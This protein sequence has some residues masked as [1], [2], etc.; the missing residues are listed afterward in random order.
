MKNHL[1]VLTSVTFFLFTFTNFIN[2]QFE[3]ESGAW[4][5]S[6]KKQHAHNHVN[7]MMG[8]NSPV[9][10]FDVLKYTMDMDLYNNFDSPYPHDFTSD[11]VVKFKVDSTLSSIELNAYQNS[12]QINSV[13]LAGTAFTHQNDMLEITLDNTYQPGDIVEVS[14]D[15]YH[16]DVYDGAFYSGSGF[17]FTDCEP[18]GARRWFPCW[19]KPSDKAALEV[20]AIVPSSVRLGSNGV[21]VDSTF[22]GDSLYY[23]WRSDNPIAT[24]IMVLTAKK[25]YN[26][27]IYYWERPSDSAMVPFRFYYNNG[28]NPSTMANM[29]LDMCDWFSDGYGEY[30][31]EKNGFATLSSEFQWGGM[32]NQT[33]TSLCPNCWYESLV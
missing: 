28:E 15:Y 21:L 23:H 32:E 27:D 1:I 18:E 33:L 20:T 13:G 9:H 11:I 24:Y 31:F 30:P 12:L 19:D 3:S 2:A 8:P 14:I 25:N 22:V 16:K 5:C 6:Q 10:S 7:P 26:L 17:I 29:S 4:Y